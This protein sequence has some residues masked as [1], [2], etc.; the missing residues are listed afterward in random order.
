MKVTVFG[1]GSDNAVS[2]PPGFRLG[3]S[4]LLEPYCSVCKLPFCDEFSITHKIQAKIA[5]HKYPR[6]TQ[7]LNSHH[8]RRNHI[9]I[10]RGNSSPF[11]DL[12]SRTTCLF[13]C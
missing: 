4:L 2:H 8:N 11:V 12:G 13:A 3:P 5:H 6:V 10:V 9:P 7:D 1:Y